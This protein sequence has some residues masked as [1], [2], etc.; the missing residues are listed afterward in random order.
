MFVTKRNCALIFA[1]SG[2]RIT[3]SLLVFLTIINN[4]MFCDRH[5]FCVAKVFL[6]DWLILQSLGVYS[7]SL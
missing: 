7:Y 6:A 5:M 1:R 4:A 2:L 3:S